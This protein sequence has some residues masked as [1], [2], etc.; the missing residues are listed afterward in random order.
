LKLS[1]KFRKWIINTR[2]YANII[3]SKG[4]VV[5]G[6]VYELTAKDEGK[7]DRYEGVPVS[8]T[9][10]IMP[11]EFA[12]DGIPREGKK[13]VDALVY[14]SGTRLQGDPKTEYVYRMNMGIADGVEKG[15]PKK[16]FEKYL[17]PFIPELDKN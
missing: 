10:E 1:T 13:L 6:L 12:A 14:I 15:I 9:K 17:R 11:I 8:Y 5:Y 7:L 16:Y 3:P 4:D 2:G